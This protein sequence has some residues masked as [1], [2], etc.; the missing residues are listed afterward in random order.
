MANDALGNRMKEQYED[1]FRLFLPRRSYTIIRLDGKG[2]HQFTR[3]LQKP[4]C[5]EL[6]DSL[7]LS[8]F[9]T[10]N[11]LNAEFAYCQSDEISILLTD[12]AKP[13]TQAYFN[14]NL[15]KIV[16]VTSSIFTAHFNHFWNWQNR[17]K[18]IDHIDDLAFFDARAFSIADEVEV[19]NYFLWRQKDWNRNSLQ[20]LAR[21]HYSQAKLHGKKA[22]E[23]HELLYKVGVNWA[24]LPIQLK[25][26]LMVVKMPEGGYVIK[27]A[28]TFSGDSRKE[29]T[30][31]IPKRW[32][33][34]E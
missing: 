6:I 21:A 24:E 25:N 23:I 12:F 7:L 20:M 15:Q 1:R 34:N 28:F 8:A 22:A 26:G 33:E 17:Q 13:E 5:Q 3:K 29:L 11:Y 2:F 14:G 30:A 18:L 4:F 10:C 19:E 16:S 32:A 27:P 9:Y 31:L